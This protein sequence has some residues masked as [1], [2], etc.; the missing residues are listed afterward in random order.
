MAEK[1][2]FKCTTL[3]FVYTPLLY[4]HEN[5]VLQ[6]YTSKFIDYWFVYHIYATTSAAATHIDIC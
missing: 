2:E 5:F 4:V 1:W 6:F 3:V